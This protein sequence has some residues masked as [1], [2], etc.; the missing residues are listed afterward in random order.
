MFAWERVEV[1][2]VTN[3]GG[4]MLRTSVLHEGNDWYWFHV[5]MLLS[6]YL[7][8]D[9]VAAIWILALRS[10]WS[11]QRFLCWNLSYKIYDKRCKKLLRLVSTGPIPALIFLCLG[12][13]DVDLECM[14]LWQTTPQTTFKG[15]KRT[16]SSEVGM[17]GFKT[18]NS[19][20]LEMT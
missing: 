1:F 15:L 11:L 8:P 20:N 10:T 9:I 5:K 18:N 12:M 17:H 6:S 3:M 19:T 7:T 16:G 4:F 13:G 2:R 14:I